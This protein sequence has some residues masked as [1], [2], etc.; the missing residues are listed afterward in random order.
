[1]ADTRE[2]IKIHRS[3]AAD[4]WHRSWAELIGLVDI[5]PNVVLERPVD[6]FVRPQPEFAKDDTSRALMEALAEKYDRQIDHIFLRQGDSVFNEDKAVLF[7]QA[8]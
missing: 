4:Y 3:V 6:P 5:D 7:L 8:W 2:F 1:M